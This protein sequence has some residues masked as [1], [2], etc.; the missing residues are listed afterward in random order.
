MSEYTIYALAGTLTFVIFLFFLVVPLP[1]AHFPEI[2]YFHRP[3]ELLP[4]MFFAM[5]SKSMVCASL[6]KVR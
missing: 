6:Q 3:E 2:P 4:A 5:V 1:K